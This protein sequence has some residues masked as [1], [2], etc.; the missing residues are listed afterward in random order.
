M[1]SIE[2]LKNTKKQKKMGKKIDLIDELDN[3]NYFIDNATYMTRLLY[4]DIRKNGLN[5]S[6]SRLMENCI[7][8]LKDCSL[9]LEIISKN[10]TGEI[11]NR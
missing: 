3:Q 9:D 2:N 1:K 8:T 6:N 4:D 7:D 10:I 11:I 5:E